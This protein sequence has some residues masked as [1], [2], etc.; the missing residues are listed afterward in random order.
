MAEVMNLTQL[1]SYLKMS[2]ASLYHLLAAGKIPGTKVGKQWRFSRQIIDEWLE[3]EKPRRADILVVEDDSLILQT[4][5]KV[6]QGAGHQCIG[7]ATVKRALTLLN[8]I[9]FDLVFLDLL[10]PDGTGVDVISAITSASMPAEVVVVT[11]HPDHELIQQ[12]RQ[13]VPGI[14][15]LNKP[16]KLEALLELASRVATG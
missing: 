3:G 16:V 13:L 9:A 4:V 2:Q 5:V 15:V 12:A 7:A 10:L 1:A 6:L 14:T 11:G 8:E